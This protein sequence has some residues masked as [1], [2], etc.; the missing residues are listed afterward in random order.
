MRNKP[1]MVVSMV[2]FGLLGGCSKQ[3]QVPIETI[4][5]STSGSTPTGRFVKYFEAARVVGSPDYS[6][7]ASDVLRKRYVESCLPAIRL[8]QSAVGSS[9]F[10]FEPVDLF[11]V[12]EQ[13]GGWDRIGKA[14]A[15]K[16]QMEV[17]A[18]RFGDASNTFFTAS[19]FGLDLCRGSAM[20]AAQGFVIV[21]EARA[22]MAPSLSLMSAAQL[23]TFTSRMGE[24]LKNFPD[25]SE[26]LSCESTQVLHSINQVVEIYEK[27]AFD[28]LAQKIGAGGRE[29]VLPL[30]KLKKGS[31]EAQAF[32]KNWEGEARLES[33]IAQERMSEPAA[34]RGDWPAPTLKNRAWGGLARSFTQNLRAVI[35][36]RD[37]SLARTR[38]MALEA[39]AYQSWKGGRG[40]ALATPTTLKNALRG[41]QQSSGVSDLLIDPFSGKEFIFRAAGTEFSVYS[42]GMNGR[43]D[44]GKTDD[45]YREP[46]LTLERS[47]G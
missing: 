32:F 14:F 38:L 42:V 30:R 37:R 20:D 47:T 19:R 31:P 23:S 29:A 39:F 17:E 1:W 46:D 44:G 41:Y 15:W 7:R 24:L 43:D 26:M 16:I 4:P 21:D 25:G 22:A 27:Q 6:P 45:S 10:P 13:A 3:E 12:R 34:K 28:T 18:G 8:I 40:G 2:A 33:R 35:D 9:E 36:I 11:G 5:V